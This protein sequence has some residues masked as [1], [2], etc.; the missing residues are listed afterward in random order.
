M[1]GHAPFGRLSIGRLSAG[2][3]NRRSYQERAASKSAVGTTASTCSMVIELLP[4]AGGVVGLSG[5]VAAHLLERPTPDQEGVSRLAVLSDRI[6][7]VGLVGV[8]VGRR[9]QMSSALPEKRH[10]PAST[11]A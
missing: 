1:V 10:P 6:D 2:R 7:E 8:S 5:P 9:E 11:T 3:S 4:D